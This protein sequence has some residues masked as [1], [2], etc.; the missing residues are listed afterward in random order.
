MGQRLMTY[1]VS[2]DEVK[3]AMKNRVIPEFND[4]DFANENVFQGYLDDILN[5]GPYREP[6]VLYLQVFKSM[7]Q[8]IGKLAP[9]EELTERRKPPFKLLDK[10][11]KQGGMPC[12]IPSDENELL[13][14]Y[15]LLQDIPAQQ[16]YWTPK[17]VKS[18]G[19]KY[20]EEEFIHAV[21]EVF[22][23][24]QSEEKDI[25]CFIS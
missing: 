3:K 4:A 25:Y 1:L 13:P 6:I 20:F 9:I 21:L 12:G 17:R 10:I 19:E 24:A 2:L 16:K 8:H 18:F 11:F 22:K 15:I 7:C 5:G 23:L 14:Y